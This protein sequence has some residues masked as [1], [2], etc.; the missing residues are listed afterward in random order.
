M[1]NLQGVALIL[2]LST[3]GAVATGAC[4]TTQSAGKQVDDAGIKIA[5]KAKLA[6]DVRFSTLTNIEVNS[7]NGVVTLAGQVKSEADRAAAGE[8]ARSV[9]GVVS[10]NNELQVEKR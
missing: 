1:K 3:T 7:T 4:R 5:V 9:E 8:L 6:K 2:A 10:V